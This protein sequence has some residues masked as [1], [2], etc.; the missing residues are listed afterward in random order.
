VTF[1]P[2]R[3]RYTLPVAGKD[4][5]LFGELAVVEA[6]EHALKDGVVQI[7]ARTLGMGVGD[8]AKLLAAVLTANGTPMTAKEAGAI[9]FNDLGI[10]SEAF[11]GLQIHLY[12]FL[13]IVL[14]PP[15]ARERMAQRM[16]ELTGELTAAPASPGGNTSKSASGCSA[17]RRNRSGGRPP[18][19]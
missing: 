8:T 3:P 9:L 18:G 19:T 1:E 5:D 16:G 13:R 2:A 11:Q 15:E 4:Y 6:V 17:G 14:E 12:A 7:T 10:N